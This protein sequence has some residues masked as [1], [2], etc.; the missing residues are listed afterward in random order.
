M[1]G[2]AAKEVGETGKRCGERVFGL[3]RDLVNLFIQ[4]HKKVRKQYYQ[5]LN[6]PRIGSEEDETAQ[7]G[8]RE[9]GEAVDAGLDGRCPATTHAP[10]SVG[11]FDAHRTG[12]I[13]G[14]AIWTSTELVMGRCV[15]VALSLESSQ[16]CMA[17]G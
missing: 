2:D 14:V 5:V 1:Q 10:M 17:P 8:A 4:G 12:W 13:P 6:R 16:A 11:C 15:V 7:V 9:E 3:T